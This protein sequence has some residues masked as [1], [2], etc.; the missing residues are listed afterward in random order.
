[1][2]RL[3]HVQRKFPF[4]VQYLLTSAYQGPRMEVL[5]DKVCINCKQFII[6]IHLV[7]SLLY[8]LGTFPNESNK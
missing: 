3:P 6:D 4:I 5:S 8:T 2:H 1:M 7:I